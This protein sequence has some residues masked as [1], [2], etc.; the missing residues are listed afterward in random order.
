[1]RKP[2]YRIRELSALNRIA[3]S[4]NSTL[5]LAHVLDSALQEV[6][7]LFRVEACS[8]MLLDE[9]TGELVLETSRSQQGDRIQPVRL[10]V[11][12]GIAGWVA[13]EGQP[14]LVADVQRTRGGISG[15]DRTSV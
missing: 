9:P 14:L 6:Q 2:K 12:E 5:E 4:I 3:S 13:R 1:L 11:G 8:L 15:V 10:R 7:E